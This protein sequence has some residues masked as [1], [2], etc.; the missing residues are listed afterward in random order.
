MAEIFF[1]TLPLLLHPGPWC[2]RRVL[3]LVEF[4]QSDSISRQGDER[5]RRI[6]RGMG[7]LLVPQRSFG[8]GFWVPA[9]A[10]ASALHRTWTLVKAG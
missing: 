2:W 4:H 10:S 6:D 3:S 8:R 7:R 9:C 1:L 5:L